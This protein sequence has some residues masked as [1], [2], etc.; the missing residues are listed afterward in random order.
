MP[1]GNSANLAGMKSFSRRWALKAGLGGLLGA[2][3]GLLLPGVTLAAVPTD[4]RLV[5]VILRG[6][7]D[8]L[9]A[10]QPYGDRNLADYR[11]AILV[12]RPGQAN[13]L[14]DLDGFFG[15]HPAFVNLRNFWQQREL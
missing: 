9:A 8:G 15:L 5:V 11:S 12:N 6:G 7:L 1:E 3:G 13:G 4:K 2:A 14:T 10:V